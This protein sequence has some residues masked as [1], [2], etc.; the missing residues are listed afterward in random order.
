MNCLPKL[1]FKEF[2]DEWEEKK[3]GNNGHFYSA[4]TPLSSNKDYYSGN[5]AL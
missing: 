5:M 2:T 4:G 3:L 1:R